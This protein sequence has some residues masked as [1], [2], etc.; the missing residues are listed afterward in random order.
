MVQLVHR[1][2][3]RARSKREKLAIEL[4]SARDASRHRI[5]ADMIILHLP[6]L[7]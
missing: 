2:I 6:E 4:V 1:E 7:K 5:A 3:D